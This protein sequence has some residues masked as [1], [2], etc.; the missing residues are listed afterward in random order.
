M[1]AEPISFGPFVLDRGMATLLSGGKPVAIGHRAY[2]LLEALAA[3]DG[4]VDKATLIEAAW[5]GT[6][7]EDGNLTVQIAALRKALGARPDGQQ[8]I[9]T[10]PRVG[11][12]LVKDQRAVTAEVSGIPTIAVLPFQNLSGDPAQDYFADGVVEDIITALSRFRSF[13]VIAR[14]STFAY[15][16]RAVDV[17]ELARALGVAYVLQGSLRRGGANCASPRNSSTARREQ[18]SG[19]KTS[20]AAPRMFSKFRT[21]SSKASSASWIGKYCLSRSTAPAGRVRTVP[22]RTTFTCRR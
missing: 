15:K 9:V 8:W 16:G 11:Y 17:R 22:R 4:P 21:A 12:R 10:V 5:P 1:A 7:V 2:A 3:V 6:I 20:M 13:A 18:T 19:A 14:N